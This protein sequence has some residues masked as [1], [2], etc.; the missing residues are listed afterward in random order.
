MKIGDKVDIK[1]YYLWEDDSTEDP[2]GEWV[3]FEDIEE[4]IN[5]IQPIKLGTS[6]DFDCGWLN[7]ITKVKKDLGII[8]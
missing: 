1:R 4:I 2:D 6:L 8:K 5:S 7:A 3:R